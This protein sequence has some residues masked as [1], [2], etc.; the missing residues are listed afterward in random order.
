MIVLIDT[1]ENVWGEPHPKF[2]VMGLNGALLS[3]KKR[4]EISEE[5]F[6]NYV[7]VLDRFHR[8]QYRLRRMM[9]AQP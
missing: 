6:T 1:W 3:T 4:Y 2:Y 7:D 8:W 9:D 5:D